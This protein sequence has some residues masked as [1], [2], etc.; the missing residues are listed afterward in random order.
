MKKLYSVAILLVLFLTEASAQYHNSTDAQVNHF[1]TLSLAGGESQMLLTNAAIAPAF[2]TQAG[3][4]A[5]FQFTYELRKYNFIFGLG[6]QADYD[7]TRQHADTFSHVSQRVDRQQEPI[8]YAYH[9]SDYRDEQHNVQVSVPVYF[10]GNIGSY[11]YLLAGAKLSLSMWTLHNTT[12]NLSTDGTYIRFVHTIQDAPYYGYYHIDEYRYSSPW[13]APQ[14]KVSPMVEVGARI[15]VRSRTGRV[16]MRLG[17]YAEYGIPINA[18]RQVDLVNYALVD[19]N[20]ATMNQQNLKNRIIFNSV[21][22]ANS[23]KAWSQLSVGL[24][25]TVL[26]NVTAPGHICICGDDI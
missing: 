25:W 6:A 26:F 24:R 8:W 18:G 5:L 13:Q 23:L 16:G 1:L 4:D 15:P 19:E 3:A 17:A 14:F 2:K 21:L 10:G 11:V 12:T 22:N 20:P 7:F 9:Y